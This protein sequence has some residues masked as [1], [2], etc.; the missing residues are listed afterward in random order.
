[1]EHYDETFYNTYAAYSSGSARKVVPHLIE[2]FSPKSVVDVG[3]GIGTWLSVFEKQGVK[4]ILGIDGS[5][6]NR[7]QL[8]FDQKDFLPHDLTR[9]LPK[10]KYRRFDLA[11]S[12]EVGEHLPEASAEQLVTTLVSLAPVVLFSAAIPHQGGTN[13]INEQWQNYWAKLFR[14]KGYATLNFLISRIWG[15][16]Q[17]EY[18]YSQNSLLYIE[19]TYLEKFQ[20]LKEYVVSADNEMLS[21]VHPIKWLKANN[22]PPPPLRNLLKALPTSLKHTLSYH[23]NRSFKKSN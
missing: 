13:H 22:R 14:Q 17:V 19:T 5:Y 15:D 18:Y 10:E 3:C 6:V 1:M 21:R 8:L 4:D 20:N 9:P 2:I 12:L 23:L 11:M 7:S 16:P